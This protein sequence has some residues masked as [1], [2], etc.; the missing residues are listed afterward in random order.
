MRE[1]DRNQTSDRDEMEAKEILW[2]LNCRLYCSLG[3]TAD[4]EYTFMKAVWD[5]FCKFCSF[6]MTNN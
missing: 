3:N 2:I 1:A 6:L 5:Q 4:E